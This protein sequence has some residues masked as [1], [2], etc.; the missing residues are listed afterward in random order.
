MKYFPLLLLLPMLGAC[1]VL[2]Q[3]SLD[4]PYTLQTRALAAHEHE[5]IIEG[6]S[7]IP[8][9]Q[10]KGFFQARGKALCQDRIYLLRS[11]REESL[12]ANNSIVLTGEI[13][14]VPLDYFK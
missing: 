8:A 9:E 2:N 12:P 7:G 13:N 4:A 1:A 14:C 6:K 3:A 5:I 11:L 10:L